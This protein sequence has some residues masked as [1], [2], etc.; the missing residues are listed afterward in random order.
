MQLNSPDVV[1]VGGGIVG[2]CTAY[3][4]AKKGVRVTVVEAG[5]IAAGASGSCD[6]AIMIQSKNP[7]LM[8]Q[9]ALAGAE[10]YRGLESELG[11]ELEYNNAGG[12]ILIEN[13]EEMGVMEQIVKRQRAAGI[14]VR[15]I[16]RREAQERQP[17]VS[18]HILG[19]TY[20]DGDADV[21]PMRV[22]LAMAGAAR[23]LGARF[24]LH[25]RVSGFL[26]DK[27]RVAGVRTS[28][29]D[30]SSD[31]VLI[32]AG[33]WSPE[34]GQMAGVNIPIVPRKGQIL[35][36][37]PLPPLIRGNVLS[38]SYIAS[39]HNPELAGKDN[40]IKKKLGIGLSLGQTRS[41]NLLVGGS[42]QF[43]EYDRSTNVDAVRAIAENAARLF[44][45][46]KNVRIIRTFAGLRPYTPDGL[47]ILGPAP[48][49][50]GLFIAAG[51]EGDGI[52]LGP[53]TGRLMAEVLTGGNHGWDLRPFRPE[54]FT[55]TGPE[56]TN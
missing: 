32:A 9:M 35:V 23:T 52:A 42:R 37:E 53:F 27:G 43:A 46:L 26:T 5:D 54:R 25:T 24:L 38:G 18:P 4:L 39:K 21:N 17:A 33:A 28:G 19:S 11:A 51:H 40:V 15:I 49:R 31:T 50:P 1:I 20:W 7:G 3:F 55:A 6:R 36:T 22:C 10:I 41:G 13:E 45:V 16:G 30:I 14:D 48:E 44:P 56:K 47:P 34:L 29:G 8:M 12:M 2:A